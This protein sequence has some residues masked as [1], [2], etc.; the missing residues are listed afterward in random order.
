MQWYVADRA[1][2]V[3]VKTS[4]DG[5]GDAM[6]D[7]TLDVVAGIIDEDVARRERRR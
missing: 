4:G 5:R 3:A 2:S 6:L 1:F 7:F